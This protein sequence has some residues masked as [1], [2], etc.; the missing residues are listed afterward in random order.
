[1]AFDPE[2]LGA[3]N[4]SLQPLFATCLEAFRDLPADVRERAV[5][6]MTVG[7]LNKDARRMMTD[8]E[9]LPVTAGPWRPAAAGGGV[10]SSFRRRAARR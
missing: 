10:S 4:R 5:L 7:S 2:G 6:Y 3:A 8:G 9:S 1:M